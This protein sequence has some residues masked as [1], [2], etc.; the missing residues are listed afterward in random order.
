MARPIGAVLWRGAS[1]LDGSLI[2]VI[3]T[4]LGRPS[5][6]IKTGP[7]AQVWILVES[8]HPSEVVAKGRDGAI[9]G[10][11]PH[12]SK[13]SGGWGSCYVRTDQAPAGVWKAYHRGLYVEATSAAARRRIGAGLSIRI[14]A[15]GDPAAVPLQVW[16]DLLAEAQNHVGYTHAWARRPGLR[17]ILMASVDSPEEAAEAQRRGWRTFRVAPQHAVP[18]PEEI[19]CPATTRDVTCHQCRLCGGASRPARSIMIEVH[20]RTATQARLQAVSS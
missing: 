8:Q 3:M 2:V 13:P 17:S 19:V 1:R 10:T 20:G 14:G 15:Y 12:R 16:H 5:Q 6:N 7:M 18:S 4:G 11:C 9:C